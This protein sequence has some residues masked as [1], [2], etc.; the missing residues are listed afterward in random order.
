MEVRYKNDFIAAA[1]KKYVTDLENTAHP[2]GCHDI[3]YYG[4]HYMYDPELAHML[5]DYQI[6]LP[7]IMSAVG[8]TGIAGNLTEFVYIYLYGFIMLVFPIIAIIILGNKLLAHYIDSGSMGV[9]LATPNSRLKILLTQLLSMLAG[10]TLLI[11]LIT[12][13]GV[14]TCEGLFP[15]ELDIPLF[16]KLNGAL[17]LFHLMLGGIAFLPACIFN[18]SKWYFSIGAGLL[19][20][21][22]L[23]QMLGNTGGDMEFFRYLTLFTLF[24]GKNI[25]DGEGDVLLKCLGMAGAAIVM[26]GCGAVCFHKKDLPL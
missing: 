5:N 8:M 13:I 12:A 26:Y 24:P 4:H 21:F 19:V 15:G 16:L 23:F 1:E 17:L 9:L 18:D 7:G 20:L 22:F 6:A 11:V 10:I 25:V 3:I 2:S 14:G